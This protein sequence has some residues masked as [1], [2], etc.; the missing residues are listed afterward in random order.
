MQCTAGFL[1]A[2][3]LI[4]ALLQPP[5]AICHQPNTNAMLTTIWP[6]NVNAFMAIKQQ[7]W[8]GLP[9]IF[10]HSWLCESLPHNTL[11]SV[12]GVWLA[13]DLP[14]PKQTLPAYSLSHQRIQRSRPIQICHVTGRTDINPLVAVP[15]FKIV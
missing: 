1:A 10:K 13:D 12:V 14:S 7:H 11:R 9:C 15:T 5:V 4:T 6:R 8:F 2:A 3:N